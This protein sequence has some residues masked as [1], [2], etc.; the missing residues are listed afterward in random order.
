MLYPVK[1]EFAKTTNYSSASW[2]DWSGYLC[3]APGISRKVESDNPG[4]AGLI[5]FD[6]ALITLYYAEGN[7]VYQRFNNIE[8]NSGERYLIRISSSRTDKTYKT[9]FEGMIDFST[10]EWPENGAAI[11]FEAVDKLSALGILETAMPRTLIRRDPNPLDGTRYYALSIGPY[12]QFRYEVNNHPVDF[13]PPFQ[14]GDILCSEDPANP[15]NK[16]FLVTKAVKNWLEPGEP[17]VLDP[18][19]VYEVYVLNGTTGGLNDDHYFFYSGYYTGAEIG[20]YRTASVSVN[21]NKPEL[22]QTAEELYAFDGIKLIKALIRKQWRD[23]PVI[24]KTGAASFNI[25]LNYFG[26]LINEKPFNSNPLE[27]LK[28]LANAMNCYLF[29][30][31]DG[32]AVIQSRNNLTGGAARDINS[33]RLISAV[34]KYFW[35]KLIDGVNVTVKS[36][37][38]SEGKFLEGT[39][40]LSYRLP[41]SSGTIEPKNAIEKEAVAAE[42]ANTQEELDACAGRIA[43]EYMLFYGKR[44]EAI[45]YEIELNDDTMEWDLIDHIIINSEAYFFDKMDMDL[46][47]RSISLEAV[48]ITGADYDLR[49]IAIALSGKAYSSSGSGSSS[50]SG[51][52]PGNLSPY[53][54]DGSSVVNPDLGRRSLGLNDVSNIGDKLISNAEFNS[55]NGIGSNI[56]QQL[57]AKENIL[58]FADPL[59]RTAN[60][61]SINAGMFILGTSSDGFSLSGT[62]RPVSGDITINFPQRLDSAASPQF[63]KLGIGGGYDAAYAL[64][65]YGPVNITGA[66]RVEGAGRIA[67]LGLGTDADET[68]SLKTAAGVYL[69][70]DLT[71]YGNI[72]QSGTAYL[73]DAQHLQ[74]ESNLIY[75][76]KN[77]A[78]AGV[79]NGIAGIEVER[80]SSA[81]YQFIFQESDDTF[82]LGQL[83]SLQAAATRQDSPLLYG[84]AYWNSAAFRFDTSSNL[85]F[86]G[87][88]LAIG[89]A[90]LAEALNINGNVVQTGVNG[91]YNSFVS[92]YLGA[93]WKLWKDAAGS[94]LEIDNIVVRNSFRTHIFQKDIAR[95]SNGYFFI[96][97]C[98]QIAAQTSS[99]DGYLYLD[100]ANLQNGDLVWYK[101]VEN[102][103]SAI[104]G[105]KI[106]ISSEG[107]YSQLPNSDKYGYKYNFTIY[108]G[109]GTFRAGGTVVRTGGSLSGR[110]GSIYFDAS[111]SS[112]PFMDIYDGVNAWPAFASADK[113]KT[114]LGK[115][116]GVTDP[117]FG[118]LSGYG[119]YSNRA[120]LTEDVLI[121]GRALG[122]LAGMT[123][124]FHFDDNLYDSLGGLRPSYTGTFNETPYG[125]YTSSDNNLS[126]SKIPGKFGGGIAVEEASANLINNGSFENGFTGWSNW[127]TGA[128]SIAAGYR[129]N[130]IF[131]EAPF[132]ASC[133]I[134][135]NTFAVVSGTVYTLQVKVKGD[136]LNYWYIFKGSGNL[137]ITAY[138]ITELNGGWKLLSY[139]YAAPASENW[140]IVYAYYNSAKGVI[141]ETQVEA[142]SF[143]TSFCE[144]SRTAGRLEF[145]GAVNPSAFTIGAWIYV[146]FGKSQTNG[147]LLEV[148]LDASNRFHINKYSTTNKL[149]F[150]LRTAG[151]DRFVLNNSAADITA[152]W[153]YIAASYDG[154]VYK[155]Y[156]DGSVY[157][158]ASSAFN[159]GQAW[160]LR[161]GYSYAAAAYSNSLYDDLSIFSRALSDNEIKKIYCSG[162]PLQES[163]GM[164]HIS[165]NKIRTGYMSSENYAQGI[166][167]S[168]WN[169]NTGFL[170]TNDGVFRGTVTAGAGKIAAFD[171][172]SALLSS[173]A[174]GINIGDYTGETI[175]ANNTYIGGRNVAGVIYRDFLMMGSDTFKYM[176]L[177]TSAG[178]VQGRWVSSADGS[179]AN[180]VYLG[181]LSY[182]GAGTGWGIE[183]KIAGVSRFK[184]ASDACRIAA[185]NFDDNS[186]YTGTKGTDGAYTSAGFTLGSAGFLSFQNTYITSGG[187]LYTKSGGIGGFSFDAGKLN[188]G[189]DFVLDAAGRKLYFSNKSSFASAN[190]GLFLGLDGGA[191][192]FI[193]GSSAK[194]LSWDGTNLNAIGATITGGVIQTAASN[195][196]IVLDSANK[197]LAFYNTTGTIAGYIQ[198]ESFE[199]NDET[200]SYY[201]ASGAH[202][203]DGGVEATI[204]STDDIYVKNRYYYKDGLTQPRYLGAFPTAPSNPHIA[205]LWYSTLSLGMNMYTPSGW[206][207]LTLI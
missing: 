136:N 159:I 137:Q 21:P 100:E 198:T 147:R 143:A 43:S 55:L 56:Q 184:G 139:T 125:L 202:T 162:Q 152:G 24:N 49:R 82:R 155:L 93:G 70:G 146:N 166:S 66:L 61:I 86:D 179:N 113:L 32:E 98:G 203:F 189:T 35:D 129:G 52:Y 62:G 12:F 141:D 188:V 164:T 41:G 133:G 58:S 201:S 85:K 102:D 9:L 182:G 124:L 96:S 105:I 19:Y 84:L 187:A 161:L 14:P 31:S 65:V 158:S 154:S 48:K 64:K 173:P 140:T 34:K 77:E 7:P 181:D 92:G 26:Q 190:A 39:S 115:L 67:R 196:R 1:I 178:K 123:A 138:T 95:A 195:Q 127:Q 206:K 186:L 30:N 78:G 18:Y 11:S 75:I 47:G 192:K 194:Y 180:G 20:L 97:D 25:P 53:L 44:H 157:Y 191:Y 50:Y 99:G 167:G 28:F 151:T 207:Q 45:D 135:S 110:Q 122:L 80:G 107:I 172:S 71:V 10:I 174:L 183:V 156:V 108:S 200:M 81:N 149:E 33:G 106:I 120:F 116:D 148:S 83:G 163:P 112:A 170:E 199:N 29:I 114:R 169:L 2:E 60:Q 46:S 69:G 59:V 119:L 103:G 42:D 51:G 68:L 130:G 165:G 126:C 27:A 76:N 3:E 79:T 142:K 150:V 118:A 101:D 17:G 168:M 40:S 89:G 37:I 6:N 88:H 91:F 109:S 63:A 204:I 197:R 185:I 193:I 54:W 87:T 5:V 73:V 4:E 128:R 134:G 175:A 121:G 72:Y 57:N 117:S 153:H 15:D 8:L 23:M 94:Y 16:F 90:A 145:S 111:S 104:T 176:Q 177:V 74:V 132:S 131:L 22:P 36:C 13:N 160:V 205:D 38:Q 144:S 171:I